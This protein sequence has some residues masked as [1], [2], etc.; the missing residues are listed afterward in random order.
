MIEVQST[1]SGAAELT[2]ILREAMPKAASNSVIAGALK[3]ASVP[4]ARAMRREYRRF[5]ASNSLSYAVRSWR[6]KRGRSKGAVIR[7]GPVRTV[8]KAVAAYTGYYKRINASGMIRHAHLIERG[9][10]V[11]QTKRGANRGKMDGKYI[12]LHAGQDYSKQ[13]GLIFDRIIKADVFKAIKRRQNRKPRK[14]S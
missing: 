8:G 5:G 9:T 2:A 14:R 12:A 1:I 11:R 3:K 4:I 10:K 6:P 13:A 7:V